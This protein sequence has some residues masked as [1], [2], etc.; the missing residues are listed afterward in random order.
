[1]TIDAGFKRGKEVDIYPSMANLA[2]GSRI[3]LSERVFPCLVGE[4]VG[5][6]LGVGKVSGAPKCL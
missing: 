1:M 6:L 3:E 5:D 4:G 2:G